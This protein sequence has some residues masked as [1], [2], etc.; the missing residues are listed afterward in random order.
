MTQ[1]PNFSGNGQAGSCQQGTDA[2]IVT[3]LLLQRVQPTNTLA[4]PPPLPSSVPFPP[5]QD[6]V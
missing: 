6:P 4:P 3:R 5:Q 2:M 1:G